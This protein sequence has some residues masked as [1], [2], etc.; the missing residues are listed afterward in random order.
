MSASQEKKKRQQQ[1][2]EGTEKRQ[3]Q[4]LEKVKKKKKN[5]KILAS[6]GAVVVIIA[7]A[8]IFINSN[9][10]RR[11]FSAV[12]IGDV[13]FSVAE[14]NYFYYSSYFNYKNTIYT[15][16]T[17][18]A[19]ALLPSEGSPLDSQVY[20]EET[21]ET[22]GDFFRSSA[23]EDMTSIAME[24]SEAT[25]SG[26]TLSEEDEADMEDTIT[27]EKNYGAASGFNTFDEY[28]VDVYGK[29]M[30]EEIYRNCMEIQYIAS[31]Y[32]DYV[33]NSFDYT[34]QELEDYYSEN[35]DKLDVISY[36]YFLVS[37][38]DVDE[39]LYEDDAALEAAQNEALAAAEE[40]AQTYL[41]SIT[42][43]A[44]FIAA[45]A[46]CNA[47]LYSEEDSTLKHYRGELLGSYYKD[48]LLDDSRQEGDYTMTDGINGYY[49]VYFISHDDN[50]YN[51][52]NV[53]H[54]LIS[55]EDVSEDDY[56]DT[57]SYEVALDEARSAA[58][59]KAEEVYDEWMAG[60]ATEESFGEL[61]DEYSD[62]TAEGGL[63]EQVYK[64][65]M[66]PEFND[67]CF[68][69]VRQA[70]DTDIVYSE[71]YGYHIIYFIGEDMLYS[72]VLA[73]GEMREAD[74]SAWET[75]KLENFVPG[76]TWLYALVG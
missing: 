48:W 54:I 16:Y 24:Y 56:D 71:D 57:E 75:E 35:T 18:Y 32:S 69:P 61:A 44:S 14:C 20:D 46:D 9:Y 41:D 27:M 53:R 19:S 6:I 17:D 51:T 60:D 1:R 25:A 2:V 7:A 15:D 3:I 39:T 33:Y 40:K 11:N 28:L 67:W 31:G 74:Y 66:V 10:L 38:E 62:D 47:D 12:K 59:E 21:G 36:R 64:Y 70:G 42:D 58:L 13:T 76:T 5:H 23:L 63:Y 43:E 8:A 30:T 34:D 29:G 37:S 50:H 65:Q 45:A 52:V 49:L 55:P 73:D 72:D 68:D 22:W 26:Y 4:Q